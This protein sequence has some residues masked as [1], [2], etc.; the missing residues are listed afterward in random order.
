MRG[1]PIED[2]V[3]VE[4]VSKISYKWGKDGPKGW[5]LEIGQREPQDPVLKAMDMIRTINTEISQLGIW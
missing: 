1:Y 2:T 3:F 4:R 5:E